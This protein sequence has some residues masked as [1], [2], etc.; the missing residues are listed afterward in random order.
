MSAKDTSVTLQLPKAPRISPIW[1]LS[2]TAPRRG[3]VQSSVADIGFLPFAKGPAHSF[4]SALRDE[5]Y[6]RLPGASQ[7][8]IGVTAPMAGEPP[9]VN[10]QTVEREQAHEI[11]RGGTLCRDGAQR[12][13]RANIEDCGTH[14]RASL[15]DRLYRPGRR[16]GGRAL[17]RALLRDRS[18]LP[19]NEPGRG[20]GRAATM[21]LGRG[22]ARSRVHRTPWTGCINDAG[23]NGVRHPACLRIYSP[24]G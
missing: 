1:A 8:A 21:V 17:G 11:G 13:S 16:E 23:T 10:G 14:L 12:S 20:H 4:G 7:P 6:V 18:A 3:S 19:G 2:R 24:G 5:G 9:P 22:V 15:L